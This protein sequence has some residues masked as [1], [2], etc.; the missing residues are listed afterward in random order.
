MRVLVTGASGALGSAVIDQFVNEGA[1]V[2]GVGRSWRADGG[3]FTKLRADVTK[4]ADVARMASEAGEIDA[5]I[6]VVGGFAPGGDN[7]A[8]RQMLRVNLESAVYV[9][10][11]FLPGMKA[12]DRGSLVAIGSRAALEPEAGLSAYGASKAALVHYIRSIALELSGT[13]VRANI[14]LPATIDTAAN[15][16]DMPGADYSK[17]VKP[18]SIAKVVSWLASGDTCDVSGAVLPIYGRG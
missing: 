8:W 17:W 9:F 15:R 4:P 1:V 11:A 6:H 7:D 2:F 3:P 5:L 10:N 13:G 18:A 12:R 14:V 16:R